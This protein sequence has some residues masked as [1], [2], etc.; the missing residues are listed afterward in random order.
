MQ[1]SQPKLP[2]PMGSAELSAAVSSSEDAIAHEGQ[3]QP[4]P[5]QFD[6]K[7]VEGFRYRVED[8]SRAVTKV[9][10]RETRAAE[11]RVEILNSERLKK[12]FE[13]NP[14]DLQL[15]RHDRRATHVSKVKDHLKY[16]FLLRKFMHQIQSS[17]FF[18][19][20]VPSYLLP[21]GMHV[22]DLHKKKKRKKTRST[23]PKGQKIASDPL[24]TFDGSTDLDGVAVEEEEDAFAETEPVKSKSKN[25]VVSKLYIDTSETGIS[26]SG[27]RAWKERHKKKGRKKISRHERS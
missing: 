7:Q 22:V 18:Y 11:L 25:A 23:A 19:R 8:V 14:S 3:P 13:E 21:R 10:V 2:V 12:H 1:D 9:A 4:S 26:S 15:L 27:R 5:L 20:N 16:V 24:K 6:L 17:Y